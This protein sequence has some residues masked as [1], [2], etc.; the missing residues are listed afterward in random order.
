[1]QRHIGP[2]NTKSVG[3]RYAV[4]ANDGSRSKRGRASTVVAISPIPLRYQPLRTI[5][6]DRARYYICGGGVAASIHILSNP[7]L[8]SESNILYFRILSLFPVDN[9]T[10]ILLLGRGYHSYFLPNKGREPRRR[11][12]SLDL[13]Y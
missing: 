3:Q 4:S 6:G 8:S 9:S 2:L 13:A 10:F 11:H 12:C 7:I 5:E 1:M